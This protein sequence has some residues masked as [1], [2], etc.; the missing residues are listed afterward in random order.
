M[1]KTISTI[2][3]AV[4]ISSCMAVPAF[5]YSS[6][7]P[8]V[9]QQEYGDNGTTKINIFDS[10]ARVYPTSQAP[11][12]K[13]TK[14]INGVTFSEYIKQQESDI[15][16]ENGEKAHIVRVYIGMDG[17][18][19]SSANDARFVFHTKGIT[20]PAKRDTI[21]HTITTGERSNI[22]DGKAF[23][24]LEYW[25]IKP[26]ADKKGTGGEYVGNLTW[27]FLRDEDKWAMYEEENQYES[28]YGGPTHYSDTWNVTTFVNGVQTNFTVIMT[29]DGTPKGDNSVG[30]GTATLPVGG[31][32]T[33]NSGNSGNT[34]TTTPVVVPAKTA[35][36]NPTTSKIFV[37]GKEVAFDAYNINGNNYFKLRD[38]ALTVRK[39]AKQF[40]VQWDPT[41]IYTND[42]GKQARGGI[43][44]FSGK[45]YTTVGGEMKKGDGIAKNCVLTTSPI[46]K[47]GKPVQFTAYNINGNNYF[48]LRDLGEA[49][50]FNVSWD[51]QLKAVVV[52]TSE[53]YTAD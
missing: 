9:G 21:D 19:H 41:M 23:R 38:V 10:T 47:D 35:V 13:N 48:K 20:A 53:S 32:N 28:V 50:D 44:L 22:Q 39:T 5:A 7:I 37:N 12:M 51:G 46:T 45:A 25:K 30:N 26:F 4:M 31:G 3:A 27:Q 2:L 42:E 6:D 16:L 1:K 17:A 14:T 8:S 49:F 43:A 36:A 11:A 34:G 29:T 33:S 18:M 52:N 15:T 40:E 24:D